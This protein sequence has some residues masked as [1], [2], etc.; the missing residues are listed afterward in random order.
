MTLTE[1]KALAQKATPRWAA[2]ERG[3]G[4]YREFEIHDSGG[5]LFRSTSY[6]RMEADAELIA[7]ANPATV[8]AL[9]DDLI[10]AREALESIQKSVGTSTEALRKYLEKL[11]EDV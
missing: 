2:R 11:E 7:A 10:A 6:G 1:L 4:I 8:I 3:A 9:I 5:I